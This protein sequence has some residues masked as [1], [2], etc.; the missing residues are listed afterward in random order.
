V[1]LSDL[2]ATTFRG[3]VLVAGGRDPQGRVHAE[4]L[5]LAA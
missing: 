3:H 1:A 5:E 4:L 2:A